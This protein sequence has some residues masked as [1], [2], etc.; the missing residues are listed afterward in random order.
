LPSE[1]SITS[2][3]DSHSNDI[4]MYDF[5]AIHVSHATNLTMDLV[6]SLVSDNAEVTDPNFRTSCRVK[7]WL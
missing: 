6:P 5:L 2:I 7:N 3:D 1:N 4:S